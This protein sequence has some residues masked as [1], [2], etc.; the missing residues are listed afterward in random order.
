[1]KLRNIIT[2][3]SNKKSDTYNELNGVQFILC[4]KMLVIRCLSAI[5]LIQNDTPASKTKPLN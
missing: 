4:I 1:M 2:R 5:A 3:F